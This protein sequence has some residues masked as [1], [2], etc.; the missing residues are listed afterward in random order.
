MTDVADG[1][2]GRGGGAS[3]AA[4]V[5]PSSSPATTRAT[6]TSGA[7]CWGRLDVRRRIETVGTTP[8]LI[9]TTTS[10]AGGQRLLHLVNVAPIAQRFR[11][12]L[13]DV[14][15]AGGAQLEIPARAG[16]MLPLDVR[17]DDAVLRWSTAEL[18]G[19]GDGSTVLLRRGPG[20]GQALIETARAVVVDG[21][22][23]ATRTDDGWL[24][25]WPAG[26]DG[27]QLRVALA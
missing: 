14:D 4:E 8:G 9:T 27:G 15:V 22:A 21:D 19:V 26:H 2:T 11:V 6:W 3:A 5:V 20:A 12:S 25:S 1:S 16:L 24:V 17:L 13:G 7:R 18:D 23:D 10:D